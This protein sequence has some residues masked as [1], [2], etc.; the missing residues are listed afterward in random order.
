VEATFTATANDNDGDIL[1]YQWSVDGV[2]QG[3]DSNTFS[4]SA[5][6]AVQTN[7]T[8]EVTVSDGTDSAS[9]S[10]TLTVLAPVTFVRQ[11]DGATWINAD[12]NNPTNTI[13]I[14]S[15]GT[16]TYILTQDEQI[17]NLENA[18]LETPPPPTG[19]LALATMDGNLYV[20]TNSGTIYQ[21]GGTSW[22]EYE[23]APDGTVD[24][25]TAGS[26]L[27]AL[28]DSGKL[29]SLSATWT[30]YN[31]PV[32]SGSISI[33]YDGSNWYALTGAE[34]LYV[35]DG[36]NWNLFDNQPPSGSFEIET[37]GAEL[38]ALVH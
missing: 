5:T 20:L 17:Y 10:V 2:D 15:T 31:D 26:V 22:Q 28:T 33:A 19:S 37:I 32:P 4:Y 8:V 30:V 11:F 1:T 34:E 23:T 25:A 3:T 12:L 13:S 36:A 27:Y 21:R 7:Y 35:F 29:Y 9:D 38:Y 16:T 24:I 6:P 18:T 14:T